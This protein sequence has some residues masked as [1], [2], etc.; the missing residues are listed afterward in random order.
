[1]H[2][3]LGED[4]N[5]DQVS[6]TLE[7][8]AESVSKTNATPTPSTTVANQVPELV[9]GMSANKMS[10]ME[11]ILTLFKSMKE[12]LSNST[13]DGALLQC[14]CAYT[15]PNFSICVFTEQEKLQGSRN[16]KKWY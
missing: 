13:T 5:Q 4:D 1:V 7:E 16:F 2:E 12:K 14:D 11:R 8:L 9:Q 3:L 6:E 15:T 10:I